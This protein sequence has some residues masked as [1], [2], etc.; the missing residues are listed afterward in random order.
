[1]KIHGCN[2]KKVISV[3]RY[4]ATTA[5]RVIIVWRYMAATAKKL[6]LYEDIWLQQQKSYRWRDKVVEYLLNSFN[7]D[8]AKLGQQ[9]L[10]NKDFSIIL[11]ILVM[12]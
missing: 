1:M 10:D 11:K 8:K 9:D 2:S 4:M 12:K 3:W 7:S 6:F 5:K